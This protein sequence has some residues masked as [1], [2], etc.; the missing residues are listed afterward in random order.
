VPRWRFV[1][2]VLALCLGCGAP[3][4]PQEAATG[5]RKTNEVRVPSRGLWISRQEILQ[6]PMTGAAWDRLLATA[7]APA[8]PPNIAN[9][10]QRNDV[11]VMAKALVYART[12]DEHYR[13]E[14]V[15]NLTLVQGTEAGAR[16]LAVGF[17]LPAYVIAADLV[18]LTPEDDTMF[19]AWLRHCLA[20]PFDGELLLGTYE[21]R[22]NNWGTHAGAAVVASSLYLGDWM[23]L[24]RCLIIFRGWLGDR[25]TYAGFQYGDLS[26]QSD[27]A[28]PVPINPQGAQHDVFS[29]D[30]VLPDD[31]R[32]SG[33]F[34]WPPPLEN[35]CYTALQG[36]FVQAELL[37]RAGFE[38]AWW[39][40]NKALLRACRWLRIEAAYPPQGDDTWMVPL[41]DF[42]YG[43]RFWDGSVTHAGK[44]VGWTDWTHG[45]GRMPP[46]QHAAEP[47]VSTP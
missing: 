13:D 45:P 36:A 16:T 15:A 27:P 26:W 12:G 31:Q 7:N 41:A 30:G 22:P 17:A 6:L 24:A 34:V 47:S 35:Y 37:S 38:E 39:W 29:I 1:F 40:Q 23:T 32:R 46:R 33:S 14:V 3:T 4:Q 5:A 2:L 43:T 10:D 19:R 8:D 18:E 25:N 11:Q 9:Q 20:V 21:R 28:H 44:G 42:H